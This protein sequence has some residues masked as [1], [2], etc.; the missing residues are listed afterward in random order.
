MACT[1]NEVASTSGCD[2]KDVK[3]MSSSGNEKACIKVNE[4]EQCVK[5]VTS[6][7]TV[8]PADGTTE[9]ACA[10]ALTDGSTVAYEPNSVC[11]GGVLTPIPI[12]GNTTEC[13]IDP[14][15]AEIS[16]VKA[17]KLCDCGDNLALPT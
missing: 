2:C 15:N 11:S 12:C 10:S 16:T 13:D 14:S 5:V 4:N 7:Y 17:S 8:D 1:L 6:G 3:C 9:Q